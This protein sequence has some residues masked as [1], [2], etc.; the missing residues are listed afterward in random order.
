MAL[1]E[2]LLLLIGADGSTAVRELERV[3]SKAKE[4]LAVGDRFSSDFLGKTAVAVAGVA[5]AVEA[6]R[7]YAAFAVDAA[8]AAEDDRRGQT[9]LAKAL[10]VTTG[11]TKEQTDAVEDWISSASRQY[12]VVDD[13]LRPAYAT[14]VRSTESAVNAQR[15]LTLA[16]DVSAGTG[17]DLDTVTAA[18]AK[19][20]EGN[21]TA[22]ARL[23]P[24]VSGLVRE[25]A[26]AEEILQHL[27]TTFGGTASEVANNAGAFARLNVEVGEIKE[28][29]GKG[30][31]PT[32]QLAAQATAQFGAVLD[33]SFGGSTVAAIQTLTNPL[34]A[35][36]GAVGIGTKSVR[37]LAIDSQGVGAAATGALQSIPYGARNAAESLNDANA[38]A[39]NFEDALKDLADTADGL[40]S[41]IFGLSSA[42]DKF[43]QALEDTAASGGAAAQ[44][45]R[46]QIAAD[47]DKERSARN[48]LLAQQALIDAEKNLETVRQGASDREKARARLDVASAQNRIAQAQQRIAQATNDLNRATGRRGN[49][50][51]AARARQ[52]L[53]DAL[54][55]QERAQLDLADT[56]DRA[57]ETMQRGTEGS[58]DLADATKRLEDAQWSL[59]EALESQRQSAKQ[60]EQDGGPVGRS[61]RKQRDAFKEAATAATSIIEELIKAGAPQDVI[62]GKIDE[63]VTKLRDAGTAAGATKGEIQKTADLLVALGLINQAETERQLASSYGFGFTTLREGLE[64][65]KRRGFY[66]PDIAYQL[67]GGRASGGSV[68]AGSSYMVG[69]R[70]REILTMGNSPGWVTPATGGGA[71]FNFNG[72]VVADRPTLER[73]VWEAWQSAQRR[74]WN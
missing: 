29:L 69:E 50:Q 53:A 3:G 31:L 34:T 56:Q 17:R 49:S 70:G 72:P 61:A 15:L 25:G 4:T 8:K 20:Y 9:I 37:D 74:G 22:L 1:L 13:E 27:N 39:R 54:L 6:F 19:T 42:Q 44:S 16:L 66:V 36:A 10:E 40:L 18:L 60:D 38:S 33:S 23:V 30:Y 21:T 55:E 58:E 68:N 64:S 48:V 2:R 52:E 41:G 73:L 14:L 46:D 71:T 24:E 62:N 59:K 63:M 28:S 11:A 43:D 26:S 51:D 12:G 67:A 32:V 45:T 57:N 7:R 5:G 35:F 47:F 65:L